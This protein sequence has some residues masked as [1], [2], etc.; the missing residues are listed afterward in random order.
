MI[1]KIRWHFYHDKTQHY[2]LLST[3]I[4]S[5]LRVTLL[6]KRSLL[7]HFEKIGF[8]FNK[9]VDIAFKTF[10]CHFLPLPVALEVLMC[11]LTEGV[12]I[13]YR[14]TYAILKY[15]KNFIKTSCNNPDELITQL[16]EKCRTDTDPVAI[17]KIAFKYKLKSYYT[18][19]QNAKI[20]AFK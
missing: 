10:L 3:F 5:Y 1:S 6:G 18:K 9:L 20:D 12:K 17:K 16:R 2:K 4:G 11:F 13:I 14:Y 15:H 19:F 8:D 7:D